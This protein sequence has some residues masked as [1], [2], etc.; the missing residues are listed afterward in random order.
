M[1]PAQPAP[2]PHPLR[3]PSSLPGDGAA[4]QPEGHCKRRD[5]QSRQ[6]PHG[7]L[8]CRW[9]GDQIQDEPAGQDEHA[10]DRRDLVPRVSEHRRLVPHGTG[11]RRASF[12]CTI[13][14]SISRHESQCRG[15]RRCQRDRVGHGDRRCAQ[16]IEAQQTRVLADKRRPIS[17]AS[18]ADGLDSSCFLS[19]TVTMSAAGCD[20]GPQ[21]TVSP[22]STW[23]ALAGIRAGP[24]VT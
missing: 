5:P 17:T 2:P 24:R 21:A 8:R 1:T 3:R 20:G 12:P 19:F 15:R 18:R 11:T 23:R 7:T 22:F 4:G 6:E 14:V 9:L 16:R 10:E 13:A